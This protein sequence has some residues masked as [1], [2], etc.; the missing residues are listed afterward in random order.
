M[1]TLKKSKNITILAQRR[2][3][4]DKRNIRHAGDCE[5]AKDR[6][7]CSSIILSW[8]RKRDV[9]PQHTTKKIPGDAVCVPAHSLE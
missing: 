4:V 7:T 9:G 5:A 1:V 8:T 3:E 2:Y 6:P